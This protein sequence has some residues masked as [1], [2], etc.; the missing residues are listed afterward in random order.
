M[1]VCTDNGLEP[2]GTACG[3]PSDTDCDN[4]DT[5]LTG[6]CEPNNEPDGT[7]CGDP[8]N[9][10]CTNPDTCLSAACEPNDEPAGTT[11]DDGL[12]CT[13]PDACD[14]LGVCEGGPTPCIPGEVCDETNDV[15]EV[16]TGPPPVRQNIG[17]PDS[18]IADLTEEECRLCHEDPDIVDDANIPNRHHLLV[19]DP[20][21]DPT[22]RP[23]PSGDT[24]GNYD[25]Y[26]CHQLVWDPNQSAFVLETFRDC[27]FC[28]NTGSPHHTTAP[29]Q[30]QLCDTCHG[31]VNNPFD[32]HLIPTYQPS[33]VTPTRSQGDGLPLNSRG[34][35]AGACD[36]CHDSGL[37]AESGIVADTNQNLHHNTGF[38]DQGVCDWCHDFSQPFDE[39]IRVC[40]RC[41]G[42]ELLHNIQA[43]SDATGDVDTDGDGIPDTPNEGNII[44][45]FEN[46]FW[47]HIGNNDDC[48]G[49]HGFALASAPGT[50][51]II[52]DI[53][54]LSAYSIAAGADTSITITGSA[55]TN[56]VQTP[57]GPLAL[58]SEI[59]LTADDG[60]TT[61]LATNAI[62]E[63]SMDVTIPGT[64]A[65]GNYIVRAVKGSN[66]S[67]AVNIALIP[68]V[69]ITDDS[70]SKKK[71]VLT[72][73]GSGF[74]TK[75]EGTDADI[76]VEVNGQ[77][78]D[79]TSWSDTQIKA[80][81]SSCSRNATITVNALFGSAS[82]SDS[83][84]GDPPG[85]GCSD[86][87]DEASCVDAGCS[88]N[89]KKGIC[90]DAGGGK[91]KNK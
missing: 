25:C 56:T 55:L 17:F 75:P 77:T 59:V 34:N 74:G 67:N 3:D 50:G 65:T 11:C 4:A 23:F 53:S 45:N 31:P 16:S 85:G 44:P 10:D 24:N 22:V 68:A 36:Y 73:N 21:P 86:N 9:T 47:G 5:C 83:G 20:V 60:T 79:I 78:V 81:V 6:A 62:S 13:D 54:V 32:G 14:G 8:S 82:N 70:C 80:S 7:A 2:D 63:S 66:D 84:G 1:G 26:S 37:E 33:L 35:G 90:K 48:W 39:Q 87:T 46:P 43:D 38:F 61:I 51:P 91:D 57:D 42:F 49:C 40:E 76:N 19:G 64:L 71:G 58:D 89:S 69:T 72:I 30:A 52:P 29:A 18:S 27:I 12:F 88:W 15:C 41:H 28:H